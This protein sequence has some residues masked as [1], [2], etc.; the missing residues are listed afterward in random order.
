MVAKLTLLASMAIPLCAQVPD[1]VV[2]HA[3]TA[4]QAEKRNDF[5]TAVRE[6]SSVVS[7]LPRNAEMQSNLGVA[8]Y[9]NHDLAGALKVFRS[10]IALNENL[11]APH[12]FSGLALYRLSNPDAAVSELEKATRINP[13]DVIGQ[14]WLGYAYAAQL[15]YDTALKQFQRVLELDPNNLDVLFSLGESWLEIGR[16]ATQELLKLAPDGGR[17]WELSGE[18]SELKGDRQGA[19]EDFTGALS[20]RPDLAELRAKVT[21]LGGTVSEVSPS[22]NGNTHQQEDEIYQRAHDAQQDARQAFETI[23]RIA[24]DSYRAHQI[25]ADALSA[26]ERRPQALEEYKAVLKLNPD[27]PGIHEAMGNIFLRMGQQDEALKEFKSELQIQ[28]RS[29]GAYTNIGQVLLITGND[30]D[31]R[32]M[33]NKA[34]EMD[35]P[36]VEIYRL[37]GKIDLHRK[38]YPAA[39]KD[40]NRYLLARQRDSSAYYL[41]SQAYRGVGDKEGTAQA[42]ALFEKNSSDAKAR[43]RA[44]MRLEA[45]NNRKQLKDQ[46][47]DEEPSSPH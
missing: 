31:A 44:E 10:A 21:M 43:S 39:I 28:P 20:R 47:S 4:Q 45:L 33:L 2:Q 38:D 17:A 15:R 46:S 29:A 16:Q 13:S 14:T 26:Q 24:P 30:E 40:L 7:A 8:L 5:A 42:L 36:P 6:Y 19:L 35:R 12:L 18:Q 22:D 1:A 11:L 3:H 9:F 41:L 37:L 23:L 32:T 25:M 27:L 34:L